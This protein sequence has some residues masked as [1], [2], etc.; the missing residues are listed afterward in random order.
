MRH[1]TE[2]FLFL[3]GKEVSYKLKGNGKGSTLTGSEKGKRKWMQQ[4][5]AGENTNRTKRREESEKG[6]GK[7]CGEVL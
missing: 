4:R 7:R 5:A 2:D 1:C 3:L 6:N